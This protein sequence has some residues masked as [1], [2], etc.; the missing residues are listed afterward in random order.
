M[1]D[2]DELEV[3][4]P[5]STGEP[6]VYMPKPYVVLGVALI[7]LTSIPQLP[8]SNATEDCTTFA[9]GN[10]RQPASAIAQTSP[11]KPAATTRHFRR[12]RGPTIAPGSSPATLVAPLAIENI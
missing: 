5:R 9:V 11:A 12:A 2:P 10:A 6:V 4:V 8:P 7:A 1:I 3:S